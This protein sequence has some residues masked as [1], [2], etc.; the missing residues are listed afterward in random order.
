MKNHFD[1]SIV[2][3]SIILFNF[4]KKIHFYKLNVLEDFFSWLDGQILTFT[5]A[6]GQF[7]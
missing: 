7:L 6:T 3:Y 2:S 1:E 4:Q 5:E